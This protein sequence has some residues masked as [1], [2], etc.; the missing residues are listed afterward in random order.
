MTSAERAW[1]YCLKYEAIGKT[2]HRACMHHRHDEHLLYYGQLLGWKVLLKT[3]RETRFTMLDYFYRTKDGE[4]SLWGRLAILHREED[5]AEFHREE[6][7][8]QRFEEMAGSI[9]QS[10]AIDGTDRPRTST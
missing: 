6:P 5:A 4:T 8:D 3:I 2:N 7:V 10:M 9:S 1:I